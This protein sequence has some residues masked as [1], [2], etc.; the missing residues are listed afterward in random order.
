MVNQVGGPSEAASLLA[1]A[2]PPTRPLGPRR[3]L[4]RPPTA[5]CQTPAVHLTAPSLQFEGGR[6]IPAYGATRVLDYYSLQHVSKWAWLGWELL[7]VGAFL[8]AAL[9]ALVCVQHQRR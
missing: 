8:A 6:N 2:S 7:F 4:V 3:A 1:S 9:A 5:C